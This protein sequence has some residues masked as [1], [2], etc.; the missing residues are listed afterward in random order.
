MPAQPFA[1]VL[2]VVVCTGALARATDLEVSACTRPPRIDAGLDDPCW[3][4]AS[5][6]EQMRGLANAGQPLGNDTTVRFCR[7][8]T[9]RSVR[10]F[11]S[12]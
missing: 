1:K 8:R 9:L 3:R 12:C 4:G 6:V 7:D 10:C 11:R 2:F 5:V